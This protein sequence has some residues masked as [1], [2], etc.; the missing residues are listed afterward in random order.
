[1]RSCSLT[2]NRCMWGTRR[3]MGFMYWR[4]TWV[5]D[6]LQ[7]G[8]SSDKMSTHKSIH[9]FFFHT[10]WR[11]DFIVDDCDIQIWILL[12]KFWAEICF[13]Q[14]KF[15][16]KILEVSDH[17]SESFQFISFFLCRRHYFLSYRLILRGFCYT[18]GFLKP[19]YP[20]INSSI[21]PGTW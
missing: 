12:S 18:S 16:E 5:R 3:W 9:N 13:I 15:S 7:D 6:W 14:I 20:F 8:L 21:L 10:A 19:C 2:L 17:G 11:K 1:M 4:T